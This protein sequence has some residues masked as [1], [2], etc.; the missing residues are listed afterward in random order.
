MSDRFCI[1]SK[2]KMMV[3]LSAEDLNDCCRSCGNGLDLIQ[4]LS[5]MA[6][7]APK[8][9]KIKQYNNSQSVAEANI[10]S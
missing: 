6:S 2:G 1:K 9:Y 4:N 3:H 5:D 7:T 10:V 8:A